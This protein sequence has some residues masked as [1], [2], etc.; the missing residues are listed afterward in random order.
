VS[1]D[2]RLL[3]PEVWEM[4]RRLS[5]EEGLDLTG[6]DW[7]STRPTFSQEIDRD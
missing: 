5:P 3:E 4:P 1:P 2:D 7:R 6:A